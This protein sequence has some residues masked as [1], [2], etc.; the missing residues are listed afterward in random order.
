MSFS[1]G[2]EILKKVAPSK[3]RPP[4]AASGTSDESDQV[5]TQVSRMSARTFAVGYLN[6][7]IQPAPGINIPAVP[8]PILQTMTQ[9]N[10]WPPDFS[11]FL[12]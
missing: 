9:T 6:G 1:L 12:S 11:T 8:L 3:G 2:V 10:T 4:T 7:T 5:P